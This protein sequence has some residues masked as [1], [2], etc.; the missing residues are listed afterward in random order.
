MSTFNA[1]IFAQAVIA[2]AE[3]LP[4]KWD[5]DPANVEVELCGLR[6]DVGSTLATH[7]LLKEAP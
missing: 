1:E 4:D 5:E 7:R 3:D 6:G 2:E